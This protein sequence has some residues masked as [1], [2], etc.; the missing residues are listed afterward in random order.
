MPKIN[1]IET[2]TWEELEVRVRESRP[3]KEDVQHSSPNVLFRGHSCSRW[4]LDTTLER[5]GKGAL[6]F[7]DYYRVISKIRPAIGSLTEKAWALPPYPEIEALS[8]DY[9]GFSVALTG[10]N[11][12]GYEYMAYLRHHGFPSPLLDWTQSLYVAAYFAF[13]GVSTNKQSLN[14]GKVS[15]FMWVPPGNV[16]S[17]SDCR[18]IFHLGPYVRAHRRHVLQ[19]SHYTVC[20]GFRADPGWYFATHEGATKAVH[21]EE[22]PHLE[23]RYSCDRV[24]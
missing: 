10:G 22:N 8:R 6:S 19:Q 11:L 17:G 23:V 9:D 13:R 24:L 20:L 18:T 7:A 14:G 2:A 5:Y 16:V 1:T 4:G 3:N 21:D 12:P 15:I